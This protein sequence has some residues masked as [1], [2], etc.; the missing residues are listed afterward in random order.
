MQTN[1]KPKQPVRILVTGQCSL[2][3]GRMEFA[4]IGN[5]YIIEPLFR[6]LHRVFPGARIRTTIG[7]TD[8]FQKREDITSIPFEMF[9]A[10]S[11]QDVPSALQ[12]CGLAAIYH[13][14]GALV[15][16]TPYIDEVLD[17]DLVI[18]LAGDMW[19]QNSA[20]GGDNRFLVGLLKLRTAQLLGIKT[21]LVA[22]SPGPF[23]RDQSLGLAKLVYS[24]F[25]VVC[26]REPVSR[27]V[28]EEYGFDL[29]RTLDL[30]CP[31]FLFEPARADAVAPLLKGSPLE[32]KSKPVVGLILGGVNMLKGPWKRQDRTADEFDQFVRMVR[33]MVVRYGVNVC[34]L[35]HSNGFK[36]PLEDGLQLIHGW[37]YHL[38]EQLYGLLKQSDVADSVFLFEGIYSPS[39]TKGIIANFDMLISGRIHGAVSGLSQ[40]VPTMVIDYGHEPV[41]H[42]SRGMAKLVGLEHL[43]VSPADESQLVEKACFC[44]ENREQIRKHLRKRNVE[45]AEL[46]RRNFEVL[47]SVIAGRIEVH[48]A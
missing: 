22:N 15:R 5:Y 4:N 33:E 29:A 20:Q 45:V 10:W 1:N 21:A 6:E 30:A 35:S 42:K 48:A 14:C 16:T 26:N 46:A 40:N 36:L 43:L 32:S 12:E 3:K 27:E 13:D 38:L 2:Q 41:S 44:W 11:D 19:G 37:D 24:E 47:P 8:E 17:S 7:L 25:D 31:A 23:W 9:Y 34:L 28:L 39:E 18:D